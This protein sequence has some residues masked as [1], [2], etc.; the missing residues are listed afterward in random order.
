MLGS[1]YPIKH[2][3]EELKSKDKIINQTMTLLK[4]ITNTDLLS[5]NNIVNKL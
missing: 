4:N 2:L 1:K 3:Q 5:I